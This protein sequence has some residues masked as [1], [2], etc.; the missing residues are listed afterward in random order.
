MRTF[1]YFLGVSLIS[2][3]SLA[4]GACG[5]GS[6]PPTTQTSAPGQAAF[7]LVQNGLVGHAPPNPPAQVSPV[8]AADV[9]AARAGGWRRVTSTAPFGANGAGTALLMTDGTVMIQDN[10]ARWFAL[11]PDLNGSYVNGTWTKKA[12]L[13]AGYGPLYF[14]SAVLADGKLIVNGGEYNFGAQVESNL[15]AIYDPVAD[16]WSKVAAPTGWAQIGDAQSTVLNDGTYML[17]NCCT[18]AQALFNET[19]KT[20]SLTG[21]GKRD[22]NSEEG[23]TLLA[24]GKVLAADVG[25]QPNSE[26][27]DA[28]SGSWSPAGSLP[29]NLTQAFEIGP[30]TLRPDG[31][32]FVAGANK[33]TAIYHT[34]SGAWS[35]GPAFPIVKGKQL[36]SADG[37]TSVLAN[38]SVLIPL[39]PGVYKTPVSFY[40]FDGNTF[41]S[42][43]GTPGAKNDSTYNL[44]LLLLPTGQ[45][46]ETNGSNDVEIYT[47]NVA[48][49]QSIAPSISAVPSTISHGNTYTVSG[50]RFNGFTQANAYGDDAQAATN[51]PLV[52]IVNAATG[53]VFFARTHD[54]SSMAVASQAAVSTRFDVPSGIEL[55]ASKLF[56]IANGIKSTPVS[57]TVN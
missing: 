7:D 35:A 45:V 11:T 6:N 52:E 4:L 36:D 27:Y 56:V 48:P 44:R 34:A 21:S 15:G 47:P 57:V 14:A 19:T 31:T 51:Y 43:A 24:N 39:S 46:L 30:Q 29:G 12:S 41:T 9:A 17:G 18:K 49:D 23:W 5:G 1:R 55:G 13:P 33:N 8:T 2:T 20:F 42:I 53:H 10:G 50:L 54:H 22:S 16:A 26:L 40:I 25:S 3:V 32:V 37:P 28:S 38:G